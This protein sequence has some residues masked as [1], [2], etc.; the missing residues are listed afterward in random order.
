MK[1]LCLGLFLLLFAGTV[2]LCADYLRILSP[3]GGWTDQRVITISGETDAHVDAVRV[4][5]NSIPLRLPVRSGR[6]SRNFVT[7]PGLN[8]IYAEAEFKG[9]VLSDNVSFYAEVPS[10]AMKIVI[11]WDTDRTDVDLHVKEPTG[12]ECYYANPHTKIGGALDVDITTG[13][14][15]EVYTL[16]SATKGTYKISVYYYSDRGN[17]QTQV[18]V[19]VVLYEG[20]PNERIQEFETMLTKTG[21]EVYIDAVTLE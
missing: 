20:T 10:K 19:Y 2:T 14:G 4:V 9:K 11:M 13:Y 18:K 12:E 3:R 21:V 8:S 16:A 1:K 17:P 5:Y 7:A 6:F 15:P